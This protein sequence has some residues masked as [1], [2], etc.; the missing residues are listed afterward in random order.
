MAIKTIKVSDKGQIAIPQKI[1]DLLGIKKGDE[2][3]LLDIARKILLAR[4]NK[5]EE[6][7]RESGKNVIKSY[8]MTIMRP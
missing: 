8:P 2:L 7:M 6:Q 4:S 5:G 3:L 1:R